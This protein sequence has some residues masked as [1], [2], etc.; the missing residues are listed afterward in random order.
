M[1]IPRIFPII[2]DM[3]ASLYVPM[4]RAPHMQVTSSTTKS[5]HT[6]YFI[7]H[8]LSG[9]PQAQVFVFYPSAV[10]VLPLWASFY[11][12]LA[13]GPSSNSTP[14]NW[15]NVSARVTGGVAVTDT[16]TRL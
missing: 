11:P 6:K 2:K 13:A 3:E 12:I 16:C 10:I 1:N 7:S 8:F 5:L 14:A 9:V 15:G 4:F